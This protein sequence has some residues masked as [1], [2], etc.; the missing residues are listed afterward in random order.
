MDLNQHNPWSNFMQNG[1][2]PPSIPNQQSNPY[3][4]NTP[5]ISNPHH[6]PNFQNSP[7]ILNPQNN[8]HF[9][10][11]SYHPPPYPYQYQ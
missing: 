6:N 2:S 9:G 7:F 8:P 3:F 5:F 10:N 11:Y 4:R 1:G